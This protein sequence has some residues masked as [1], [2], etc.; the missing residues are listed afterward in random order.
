M[1]DDMAPKSKTPFYLIDTTNPFYRPLW[2]RATICI[3]VVLWAT[4]ETVMKEPFWSV[5]A[6]AAAVYCVY[7]L[8]IAYKP[9]PEQIVVERPPDTDEDAVEAD[10]DIETTEKSADDPP[11][12]SQ[13]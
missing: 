5:I 3:S 4:L 7:V 1:R 6:I 12:P 10:G 2:L 11:K 13:S 9:P 8:F